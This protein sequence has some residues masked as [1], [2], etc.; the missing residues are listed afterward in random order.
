MIRAVALASPVNHL[1]AMKKHKIK[2]LGFKIETLRRLD[3]Q[4]LHGVAGGGTTTIQS[5]NYTCLCAPNTNFCV[6]HITC[7][8]CF[9]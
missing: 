1:G 8:T 9:C 5:C 4:E 2:K 6:T 3:T 7:G